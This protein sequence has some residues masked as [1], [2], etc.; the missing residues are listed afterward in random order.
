[1]PLYTDRNR[2][3]FAQSRFY[4]RKATQIL[5]LL[6]LMLCSQRWIAREGAHARIARRAGWIVARSIGH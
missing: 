1:M 4:A 2:S 3:A 6:S 5:P